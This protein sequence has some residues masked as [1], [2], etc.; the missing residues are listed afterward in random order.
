MFAVADW[1]KMKSSE[2][3]RKAKYEKSITDVPI[4]EILAKWEENKQIQK[5][6]ASWEKKVV[7]VGKDIPVNGTQESYEEYPYIV[8]VV[9]MLSAWKNKNYGKLSSY[10]QKMFPGDISDGK[11][12]GECRRT[13]MC[14][15]KSV[16]QGILD[17]QRER[18]RSCLDFWMCI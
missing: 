8:A 9:E 5:E 15:V 14:H 10:L 4:K 17:R 3:N 2:S 6:I 7:T 1:M 16:C 18:K 13:R 12:A 11:R